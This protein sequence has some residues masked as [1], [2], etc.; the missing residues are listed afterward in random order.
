M[1]DVNAA[2]VATQ[3]S[4]AGILISSVLVDN[5]SIPSAAH[6]AGVVHVSEGAF[7]VLAAAAQESLAT[8]PAHPAPIA[9]HGS[10]RRRRVGPLATAAVGLRDVRPNAHRV[11]IEPP[12]GR[13][14]IKGYGHYF[15][16]YRKCD[17]GKWRISSK[18]NER[19]R[20]DQ[21]SWTA[22]E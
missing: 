17:D 15:E 16:T 5:G 12:S 6:P 11:Q 18:R 22:E 9:V 7:D 13:V 2:N 8:R 20:L 19:I 14:S 3:A 10:L 21:V 4:A 1:D